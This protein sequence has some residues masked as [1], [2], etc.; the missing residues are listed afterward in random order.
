MKLSSAVF[1][2]AVRAFQVDE[3]HLQI[4]VNVVAER[5]DLFRPKLPGSLHITTMS[6][7]K[8]GARLTNADDLIRRLGHRREELDGLK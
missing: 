3:L 6:G 2:G 8:A 1:N 5:K 4:V 7:F